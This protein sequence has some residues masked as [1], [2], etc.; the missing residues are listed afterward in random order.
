MDADPVTW[1]TAILNVLLL[2]MM[3][4]DLPAGFLAAE[5]ERAGMLKAP[6]TAD[7]KWPDEMVECVREAVPGFRSPLEAVSDYADALVGLGVLKRTRKGWRSVY[8]VAAAS[9]TSEY[10]AVAI[11]KRLAD[12]D[13]KLQP[14]VAAVGQ[15]VVTDWASRVLPGTAAT[16]TAVA[17]DGG[18]DWETLVRTTGRLGRDVGATGNGWWPKAECW[19]CR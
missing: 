4:N 12:L 13:K 3:G 14:I 15:S 8:E 2:Q 7:R 17:S 10:R 9:R 16:P 6:F 5:L 1:Q 11:R 19:A 18:A